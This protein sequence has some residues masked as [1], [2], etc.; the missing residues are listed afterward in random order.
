MGGVGLD[1]EGRPGLGA[2]KDPTALGPG[3]VL[4]VRGERR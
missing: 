4:L 3:G 2:G 1:E